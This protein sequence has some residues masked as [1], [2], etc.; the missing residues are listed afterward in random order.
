[1]DIATRF[2]ETGVKLF[3]SGR[4]NEAFDLFHASL[5][6]LIR[7]EGRTSDQIDPQV[8]RLLGLHEAVQRALSKDKLF[9]ERFNVEESLREGN[10]VKHMN[11]RPDD[12]PLPPRSSMGV[13]CDALQTGMAPRNNLRKSSEQDPC[14]YG[15]ALL[16][17]QHYQ[18]GF[19]EYIVAIATDLYNMA[20][21]LQRG[22][23]M[24]EMSNCMERAL[25]LYSFA[26][27]LLWNNLGYTMLMTDQTGDAAVAKLYCAVLNNTGYLLHQM[28]QFEWSQLFF[29][30]LYQ[31]LELLGPANTREEQRERDAFQLNVVVLYRTLTTAGAA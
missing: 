15:Q 13:D 3:Q 24:S 8:Y 4:G 28:G 10:V 6:V 14:L 11:I 1:M 25:V 2:N 12:H 27:D 29:Q 16:L 18:H 19:S 26:G 22:L 20:L 23:V 17:P 5:Q 7:T 21:T 9:R 30:R 31:F